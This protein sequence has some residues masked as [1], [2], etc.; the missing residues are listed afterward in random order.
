[1]SLLMKGLPSIVSGAGKLASINPEMFL[2]AAKPVKGML[3]KAYKAGP[4]ASLLGKPVTNTVMPLGY[5][6]LNDMKFMI[7][8]FPELRDVYKWS[9]KN[10]LP[11]YAHPEKGGK[12]LEAYAEITHHQGDMQELLEFFLNRNTPFRQGFGLKTQQ[13]LKDIYIPDMKIQGYNPALVYRAPG[14]AK[15]FKQNRIIQFND[16]TYYTNEQWK[17]LTPRDQ[18]AVLQGR[19]NR[20]WAK[21][22][23]EQ[24]TEGLK[25]AEPL[26]RKVSQIQAEIDKGGHTSGHKRYLDDMKDLAQEELDDVILDIKNRGY[27]PVLGGFNSHNPDYMEDVWDFAHNSL[28]S[29]NPPLSITNRKGLIQRMSKVK[30]KHD[31]GSLLTE[32]ATTDE[33]RD[34]VTR[35][36]N[37]VTIKGPYSL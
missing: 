33:I 26:K 30:D 7:R 5:T 32:K 8:E 15:G 16:P 6:A 14:G 20:N 9:L 10:G 23:M 27:H 2:S 4:G 12:F 18:Y 13:N 11:P 37:P 22:I 19:K 21:S 35:V 1:M 31:V 3:A 17:Q 28:K 36:L 24:H 25:K 29:D 34:M